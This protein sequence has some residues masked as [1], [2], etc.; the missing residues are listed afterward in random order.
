MLITNKIQKNRIIVLKV[1]LNLFIWLCLFIFFSQ[2]CPL[3]LY[4][5]D[6]WQNIG[7]WRWPLPMRGGWN[8]SRVL[9]ETLMPFVGYIA[10]Y[11]IRPI[12]GDYIRAITI[13]S[14]ICFSSFIV[15]LANAVESFVRKRI[16]ISENDS[17]FCECLFVLLS[18]AIF[19]T[20]GTSRYLFQAYDLTCVFNYTICGVV[21]L[22]AVLIIMQYQDFIAE[23]KKLAPMKKGVYIV[24][25]YLALFSHVYHSEVIAIYGFIKFC[26]TIFIDKSSEKTW[27]RVLEARGYLYIVFGWIVA[28]YFETTG[29]RA[30]HMNAGN[31]FDFKPP[32]EQ[33]LA[34]VHALANPFFADYFY[35]K[36]YEEECTEVKI[37]LGVIINLVIT[38]LYLIIL[39]AKVTYMSRIEA[40]WNIWAYLILLVVIAFAVIIK[41]VSVIRMFFL[42][43]LFVMFFMII[44]PDGRYLISTVG[45]TDYQICVN[46]DNYVLNQI[47]K[48]DKEGKKEVTIMVPYYPDDSRNWIF[49]NDMGER[50]SQTLYNHNLTRQKMN[51]TIVNNMS[52]N[53]KM[54]NILLFDYSYIK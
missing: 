23:F 21:N 11:V 33:L 5:G 41:R 25:I 10:A 48:A 12:L 38:T 7:W 9:P 36:K 40:S 46:T 16:K 18:F 49:T 6:D 45:S 27:K 22:I 31:S 8:P 1:C 29:G 26:Q 14:A 17:L 52:L 50:L 37:F 19:R 42:P 24:V 3:V 53:E 32:F 28:L 54:E 4:D 44:Q 43:I 47:M 30:K 39:C 20:R 35:C 51:I 2:I 13:A 15:A 34:M